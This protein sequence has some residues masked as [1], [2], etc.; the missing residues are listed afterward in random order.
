MSA[1]PMA[2][3]CSS[4]AISAWARSVQWE[5]SPWAGHRPPEPDS[6]LDQRS[7]HGQRR[8]PF[9]ARLEW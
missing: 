8:E 9:R 1:P 7:G 3:A 2:A 5:P 6:D 4:G